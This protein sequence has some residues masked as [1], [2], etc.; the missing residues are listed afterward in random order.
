[1]DHG[2]SP[3]GIPASHVAFP[4][5]FAEKLLECY[6]GQG[7]RL[8]EERAFRNPVEEKLVQEYAEPVPQEVPVG[9]QVARVRPGLRPISL[10][11]GD[12]PQPAPT[13]SGGGEGSD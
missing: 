12:P 10:R 6:Y 13:P 11:K 7:P 4:I 9:A 2:P 8:S 1:M 3:N 5:H